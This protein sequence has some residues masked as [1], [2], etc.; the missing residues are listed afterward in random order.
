MYEVMAAWETLEDE[1]PSMKDFASIWRSADKIV[2]STSLESV[3]T[4]RTRLERTFEPRAVEEL[5]TASDRDLSIGGPG[6][7]VHA[8]RAGLIDEWNVFVTPVIVG[9]GTACFPDGV[10]VELDLLEERRF[11]SGVVYLRY[12]RRS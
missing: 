9:G 5:K 4:A 7:A 3:S 8:T 1:R 10:R 12:R 6:L 11:G 2:Y